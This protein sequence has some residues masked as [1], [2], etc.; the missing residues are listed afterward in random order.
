MQADAAALSHLKFVPLPCHRKQKSK[1]QNENEND[2][3]MT[4]YN[5]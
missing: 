5:D 1:I 2:A 4:I 3:E